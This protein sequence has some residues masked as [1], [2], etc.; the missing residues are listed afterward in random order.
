MPLVRITVPESIPADQRAALADGVH[1]ALVEVAKA[2]ADDRFQILEVAPPEAIVFTPSYLG[3]PHRSP[4]VVVQVFMNVGRTVD[5]KKA[6][7]ASSMSKGALR[8]APLNPARYAGVNPAPL[9]AFA[10][11][12][13]APFSASLCD[14]CVEEP[15]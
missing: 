11:C 3:L 9:A 4:V 6:L 14:L 5:V 8:R 12:S 13:C 7:Y 2:P 15:F 1:R 10:R